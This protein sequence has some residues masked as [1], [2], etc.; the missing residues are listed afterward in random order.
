MSPGSR[1]RGTTGFQSTLPT[2]GE[3]PACSGGRWAQIHFNPLSP[4][5]ERH[6]A[7]SVLLPAQPI[8]I[9]SP[10]TGRDIPGSLQGF[11]MLISIHSP[12]TG[13]DAAGGTNADRAH[14][15]NPLSPHGERPDSR[16]LKPEKR[17]FQSTLPTRGETRASVKKAVDKIFQSTLPT[18]GETQQILIYQ[19]FYM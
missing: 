16:P 3:T 9:H 13:R 17:L 4:H 8:S 15:F 5:G 1:P 19:R 14:N 2:R 7:P 10:H 11:P 12:H 6:P 18:R